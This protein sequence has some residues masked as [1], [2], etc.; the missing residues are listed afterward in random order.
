MIAGERRTTRDGGENIAYTTLRMNSLFLLAA[1]AVAFVFGYRF[2]AKLLA[3]DIFRTDKNYS[4]ADPTAAGARDAVPINRHLLLAHH[5]T[6]V[7]GA[8]VFAGPV[9]ALGWGWVPAFLWLLI[10]STVA[11]GTYA[12][13]AFWFAVHRPGNIDRLAGLLFGPYARLLFL[14]LASLVLLLLITASATLGASLLTSYPGAV[15]PFWALAFLG[16]GVGIFLRG[17]PESEIVSAGFVA[18]LIGLLA[19][20]VLQRFPVEISGALQ[21]VLGGTPWLTM[22]SIFLWT[23]A[24][25]FFGFHAARLPISQLARPRSFVVALLLAAMLIIFYGALIFQHPTVVAPQFHTPA[26]TSGSLPWLFLIMTAGA[27]AGF[28]LLLIYG[29]NGRQLRQNNE[30]RYLGYGGALV[31]GAVALSAVLIAATAF[32]DGASWEKHYSLLPSANDFPRALRLYVDQYAR[33]A[34]VFG[35]D[36][37]FARHLAAAV[38]AGLALAAIETGA[39]ALKHLW[40]ERRPVT[41]V[42]GGK[43]NAE[44]MSLW[45][46]V[47][48]I[49]IALYGGSGLGGIEA[50]PLLALA[51]LWLAALGLA[52]MARALQLGQRSPLLLLVLAGSLAGIS[53][54]SSV[55]QM[56]AWLTAGA[57]GI[58][59]TATVVLIGI[60]L[61]SL[62][63]AWRLLTTSNPA[64]GQEPPA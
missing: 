37:A 17:R 14:A 58:F 7:A 54:W 16:W 62:E 47:G 6:A 42:E 22:D 18:V 45:T 43:R 27:F 9:V 46:I 19:V 56:Q 61:L 25:L 52:V 13:A 40:L 20:W 32:G 12:F 38:M 8:A 50:W 2:Y 1:V 63:L 51:S 35:F 59:G 39:R 23:L 57:W 36:P 11:A 31:E 34:S 48:C 5:V 33:Y 64:V 30:A 44:K 53:L 60:A 26:T 29:V 21:F 41:Q 28:Q 4:T 49:A 55:A 15:L 3:L 10:G 24:L